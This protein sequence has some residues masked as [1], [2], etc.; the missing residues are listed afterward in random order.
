[1]E[2]QINKDEIEESSQSNDDQNNEDEIED[3]N[4][5]SDELDSKASE[6][7]ET[8]SS[9]DDDA[10]EEVDLK[11]AKKTAIELAETQT[12]ILN[13][14]KKQQQEKRQLN[15]ERNKEQ[16][17]L[18]QLKQS[19]IEDNLSD[20]ED[21]LIDDSDDKAIKEFERETV[22]SKLKF[23]LNDADQVDKLNNKLIKKY[24][25]TNNRVISFKDRTIQ[26]NQAIKRVNSDDANRLLHKK[27]VK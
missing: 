19:K 10:P 12:N 13:R 22:N 15:E 5:S 8:Q 9:D 24:K 1:M 7:E 17:K 25:E 21:N 6:Q 26:N 2:D 11:T 23:F 14:I 3:S 27:R 18:K 16:K 4:Q 20:L